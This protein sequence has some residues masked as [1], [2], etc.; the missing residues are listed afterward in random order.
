MTTDLQEILSSHPDIMGGAV[1]LKGTRIPLKTVLDNL[2]DNVPLPELYDAYPALKPDQV[3]AIMEWEYQ[4]A[5]SHFIPQPQAYH[6]AL[7]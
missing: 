6:T 1:C 5:I 7:Q 4:Q 2:R 3:E